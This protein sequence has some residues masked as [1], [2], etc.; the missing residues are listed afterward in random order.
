MLLSTISQNFQKVYMG[1]FSREQLR[2]TPGLLLCVGLD[3]L[4]SYRIERVFSQMKEHIPQL[5]EAKH[6]GQPD[7]WFS[8]IHQNQCMQMNEKR[9]SAPQMIFF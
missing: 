6:P 7:S 4:D 1:I 3:E 8:H 9:S 5:L 2:R